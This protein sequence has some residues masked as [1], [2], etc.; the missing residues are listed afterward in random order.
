MKEVSEE[1]AREKMLAEGYEQEYAKAV[2]S[3][4]ALGVD[5]I[6]DYDNVL[7]QWRN[8]LE[9][10]GHTFARQALPMLWDYVEGNP[11]T[12]ASG[13]WLG[14]IEWI[15]IAIDASAKISSPATITQPSATSSGEDKNGGDEHE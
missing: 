7:C 8:N 14:A 15:G 2:V 1:S 13:T 11:I 10:V 4:L 12:G 6:A 5:K 9:T 3:Y